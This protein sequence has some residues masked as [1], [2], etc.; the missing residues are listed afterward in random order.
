M[1][2]SATYSPSTTCINAGPESIAPPL[3]PPDIVGSM[4]GRKTAPPPPSI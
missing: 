3:S 2:T 1:L 4:F